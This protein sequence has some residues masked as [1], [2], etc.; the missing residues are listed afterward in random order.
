[1]WSQSTFHIVDHKWKYITW[2]FKFFFHKQTLSDP[3][4]DSMLLLLMKNY[5]E[6]KDKSIYE[7]SQILNVVENVEIIERDTKRLITSLR[8]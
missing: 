3:N 8:T 4:Y 6:W 2:L 1:M 5:Q 7:L